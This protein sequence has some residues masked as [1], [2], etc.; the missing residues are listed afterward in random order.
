MPDINWSKN[1]AVGISGQTDFDD[2]REAAES[3]F[4]STNTTSANI[5]SVRF[6]RNSGRGGAQYGFS[7][8]FLAF[9]FTGYTTGTITNLT[10]HWTGTLTSS[11]A[12]SVTL[13]KTTAFGSSTNFTD[14][15]ST[16]WWSS[17]DMST[18]YT[19]GMSWAD[20]T[21]AQSHAL[22][23]GAVTFAQS[24][25]YLQFAVV[26]TSYDK[27]GINP[28]SDVTQTSY[29]NWSSNN[30]FLRFTYADASYGNKIN[31][32]IAASDNKINSIGYVNVDAVNS[33]V[34]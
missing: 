31:S 15:A 8:S 24:N 17:L 29:G 21:S 2:A 11:G 28:G 13:V 9:D 20:S 32:I 5:L 19:S 4:G 23:S 33:I 12:Q 26:N 34:S 14:Y 30:M 16:D 25:S 22:T 1:A 27:S 7:R 10:F 18:A 3:T 6:V